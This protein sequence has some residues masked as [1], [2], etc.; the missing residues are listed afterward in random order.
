MHVSTWKAGMAG[1]LAL[2]LGAS[3]PT[4]AAQELA[5]PAGLTVAA[6]SAS[7][8]RLRWR[9]RGP[10]LGFAVLRRQAGTTEW[11]AIARLP[12]TARGLEST[13]VLAGQRFEHC[14]KAIYAAGTSDCALSGAVATPPPFPGAR[15]R[16]IAPRTEQHARAGEGSIA[17]VGGRLVFVYGRYEG[18][19][20]YGRTML[21]RRESRD[22]GKSWSGERV[23]IDDPHQVALP[24][25]LTL[26]AHT[27]LLSYLEI[28][29]K[30]D[31]R[32]VIRRSRDGGLSWD[33]PVVMTD[34]VQPYLTGSHDRLR[35]LASGRLI[36]PVHAF[37]P[38][39]DLGTYVY[40]SDD[41]GRHW[42]RTTA[43]PLRAAGAL[44][45]KQF[46]HG[47][48]ETAIAELVPGK[49]LMIGRTAKGYLYRSRST[50]N[51]ETWSLPEATNVIAPIAPS[52]IVKLKKSGAIL[53]VWEPHV[54]APTWGGG[55][56]LVLGSM[57]S[58]DG[59]ETWSN[60]RQI[61]YSGQD[62][63]SYPSLFVDRDGSVNLTYYGE[64]DAF[65]DTLGNG[66]VM[67]GSRY[68]R[69]PE[70]WFFAQGSDR[71]CCALP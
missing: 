10:V 2:L 13:G 43:E 60:Y 54:D 66:N 14:V 50:D 65:G 30:S 15:G 35:R 25:L 61:E 47:F 41:A 32:R 31:A 9:H 34:G 42:R 40:V 12:A 62:W 70:R 39:G 51:G 48:W 24:S 58:R 46:Q 37:L 6:S 27:L 45:P 23:I 3:P 44:H 20:D 57:A 11:R 69:L 26:D 38:S 67:G 5:P 17:R 53:L 33:A 29:S 16:L 63:L 1:A 52:N 55:A 7:S 64:N 36:Y 49:L 8:Y 19:G 21:A 59:G 68:L 56:R 18:S 22:D 71:R 28:R 4:A